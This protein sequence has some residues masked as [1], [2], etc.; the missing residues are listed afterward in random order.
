MLLPGSIV[1]SNGLA[2]SGAASVSGLWASDTVSPVFTSAAACFR[3]AA[4]TRLTEPSWSSAP[5]RPQFFTCWKSA[6]NS[7]A[8]RGARGSS[9]ANA[10]SGA[11]R[12]AART[13]DD[14]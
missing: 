7:A 4:V 9:A 3:F 1:C 10:K 12:H 14:A 2:L 5:Q 13:P 6:S 8:L 11:M